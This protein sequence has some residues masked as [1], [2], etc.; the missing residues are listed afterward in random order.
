MLIVLTA[1][2]SAA[3][4]DSETPIY[5]ACV[6]STLSQREPTWSVDATFPY[7]HFGWET[8]HEVMV[9]PLTVYEPSWMWG[10]PLLPPDQLPERFTFV[11][12]A[13]ISAGAVVY[14]DADA[15]TLR[16]E[17]G[18]IAPDAL[19]QNVLRAYDDGYELELCPELRP[20]F[21]AR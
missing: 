10:H 14:I 13:P 4:A 15:V 11:T 6:E 17:A 19:R 7:L 21:A 20:I 2:V 16:T 9:R 1:L 3:L 5:R 8:V 12:A 18:S